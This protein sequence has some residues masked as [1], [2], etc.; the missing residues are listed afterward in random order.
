MCTSFQF[1]QEQY[2]IFVLWYFSILFEEENIIVTCSLHN[3]TYLNIHTNVI[4]V[5]TAKLGEWREQAVD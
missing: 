4:T 1:Y 3:L 5:R 2:V